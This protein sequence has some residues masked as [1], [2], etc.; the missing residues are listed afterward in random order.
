MNLLASILK[1]FKEHSEP[2]VTQ[3]WIVENTVEVTLGVSFKL[4]TSKFTG[5]VSITYITDTLNSVVG[6]DFY[7]SQ[8][9]LVTVRKLIFKRN[10]VEFINSLDNRIVQGHKAPSDCGSPQTINF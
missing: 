9:K 1:A 2:S 6:L 10:L 4:E 8:N 3:N 7:N 5:V